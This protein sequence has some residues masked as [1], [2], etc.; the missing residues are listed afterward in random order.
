MSTLDQYDIRAEELFTLSGYTALNFVSAVAAELR[1]L[2]EKNLLAQNLL[3]SAAKEIAKLRVENE[4]LKA[5]LLDADIV[6]DQADALRRAEAERVT[7]RD[8]AII[9]RLLVT[10]A[11]ILVVHEIRAAQAQEREGK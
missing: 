5:G 7:E 8:C 10:G 11:A 4:R 9:T 3:S 1:K 6:G 2:G